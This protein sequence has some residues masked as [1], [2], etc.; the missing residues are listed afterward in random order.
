V[1]S[2]PTTLAAS[3]ASGTLMPHEGSSCLRASPHQAVA[4][5]PGDRRGR[6]RALTGDSAGG[7]AIHLRH[8]SGTYNAPFACALLRHRRPICALITSPA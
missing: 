2:E 3:A 7:V 6:L 5:G 1:Q 4:I 8:H